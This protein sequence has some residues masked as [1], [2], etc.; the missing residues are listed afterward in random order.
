MA[1]YAILADI[2]LANRLAHEVL[3]RCLDELPPQTRRFLELL[4]EHVRAACARLEVA[5]REFRFQRR[6]VRQWLSWSYKQ[7]RVHLDRLVELE[8]VLVH[9]GSRGQSFVYELLYDGGG[10]DGKPFALGLLDVEGLHAA[11]TTG[12]LP[13]EKGEFAPPIA[14][15]LPPYCPPIAHRS[16]RG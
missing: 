6:E 8:Y 3:G 11:R 12:S 15:P 13:T 2:E 9:R 7:V 4:D 16:N 1:V 10:K 5:R 14:R